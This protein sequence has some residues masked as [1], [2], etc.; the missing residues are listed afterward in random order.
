M[1]TEERRKLIMDLLNSHEIVKSQELMK[2]SDSSESTIRR[3][4]QEMEADGLL[5]RIHGGA[6][7]IVK[8]DYE[9]DMLEKSSKNVHEKQ[10][11]AEYATS[12]INDGDF[13]YLDAGTSTYEMIPYL[14]HKQINVITNSVYHATA[15]TDLR[16]PTMI[17]G[18][19][20]KLT[21][22]AVVSAFS[23]QQL[24]LFRF[25]KAFMGI[26]GIHPQHGF[27]T[28]DSEEA[29]MKAVA[30]RQAEQVY[31]LADYSKFNKVSFSKVASLNEA[32]IITNQLSK[33]VFQQFDSLTTIKEAIK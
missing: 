22:K 4:L 14:E 20:I 11:V 5:K 19:N 27:T 2:L 3:D 29:T 23:L 1:L 17:I 28:P 24:E 6:K 21:T 18:G 32:T 25:D 9:P 16:I 30:L 7:R 10:L 15:L 31:I 26:N 33:E 12:F 8:L 13:V